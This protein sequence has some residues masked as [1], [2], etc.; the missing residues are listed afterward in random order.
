MIVVELHTFKLRVGDL[1]LSLAFG[2]AVFMIVLKEVS[3]RL[4]KKSASKWLKK[5]SNI[6]SSRK[7]NK[8]LFGSSRTKLNQV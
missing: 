7:T 5:S 6:S 2:K 4:S 1:K 3:I 8:I